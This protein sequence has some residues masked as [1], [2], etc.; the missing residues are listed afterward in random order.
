MALFRAIDASDQKNYESAAEFYEKALK[1]DPGICIAKDA[2]KEL[3]LLKLSDRK[4][5]SIVAAIP[6]G[7]NFPN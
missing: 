5:K 3:E 7:R 1:E 6:S 2:L 4:K